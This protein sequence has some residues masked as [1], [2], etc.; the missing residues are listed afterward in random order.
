MVVAAEK[1]G[2]DDKLSLQ[3]IL[4]KRTKF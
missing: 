4:T 3:Y 1:C 2:L